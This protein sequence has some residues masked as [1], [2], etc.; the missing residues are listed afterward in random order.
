MG[1]KLTTAACVTVS[2][3]MLGGAL[4][5]VMART[6]SPDML[7]PVSAQELQTIKNKTKVQERTIAKSD[8]FFE[9]F[10]D[11]ATGGDGFSLPAGWTTVSTPGQDD[12]W[13]AGTLGDGSDAINGVSGW[14]YGFILGGTGTYDHD[15]W[16]FSPA[17]TLTK[18]TH[19]LDFYAYMPAVPGQTVASALEVYLC[20]KPQI[21][22]SVADLATNYENLRRWTPFTNEFNVDEDGEYYLGFRCLSPAAANATMIDNVRISNGQNPEFSG[23]TSLDFGTIDARAGKSFKNYSMTNLGNAP[24]EVNVKECSPE[25]EVTGVPLTIGTGD[26]SIYGSYGSGEIK[27]ALKYDKADEYEGYVVLETS[28]PKHSEVRI[29]VTAS[30]KDYSECDGI[31][32]SFEKGDPVDWDM[33]EEYWIL[34]AY[35]AQDG[36]TAWYSRTVYIPRN[37]ELGGIGFTTNYVRLGEDPV[38][39]FWYKA[40]ETNWRG[41]AVGPA[42]A[43]KLSARVLVSGEMGEWHEVYALDPEGEVKHNPISEFQKIEVRVPEFKNETHRVRIV[44]N[45]V[46]NYRYDLLI[47]NVRVGTIPDDDISLSSLVGPAAIIAGQEGTYTVG[48][49]NNGNTDITAARL[50]L[51]D[52][53]TGDK[54]ADMACP[55]IGA[56]EKTEF[57]FNWTPAE[58][59]YYHLAVEAFNDNDPNPANNISYPLHVS[60]LGDDCSVAIVD[61]TQGKKPLTGSAFPVNFNSL[62]CQTQTIYYANELGID[63][64]RINSIKYKTL[65]QNAYLSDNFAIYVAETNLGDF[66][67]GAFVPDDRFT[68][69]F[70]GNVYFREGSHELVIPFSTPYDYKGGNLVIMAKRIA[71]NFMYGVDFNLVEAFTERSIQA[72]SLNPGSVFGVENP[73]VR[74]NNVYPEIAINIVEAPHGSISGTIRDT[75]GTPVPDVKVSVKGTQLYALTDASGKYTLPKVAEGDVVLEFDGHDYYLTESIKV[76]LAKSQNLTVD[77]VVTH[78]PVARLSGTVTDES[79]ENGID[80]VRVDVKGHNNHTVFTSE[81]GSYGIEDICADTGKDYKVTWENP[82]FLPVTRTLPINSDMVE[83]IKLTPKPSR[84]GIIVTNTDEESECSLKWNAPLPEYSYDSGVPSDFVGWQNGFNQMIV[85]AAFLKKIDIREVSWYCGSTQLPHR[86]FNVIIFGLFPDGTPNPN[87]ILYVAENVEQTDDAWSTHRLTRKVSAD[88]FMVAISCDGFIAIG[89]SEPTENNPFEVGQNYYAG[90]SYLFHISE[91]STYMPAH[92]MI[93]AYGEDRGEWS[94]SGIKRDPVPTKFAGKPVPD[95]NIYRFAPGAPRDDWEKIATVS[96]NTFADP[97]FR[98]LDKGEVRY[99]VTAVYD[100]VESIELLSP[101]IDKTTDGVVTV[102]DDEVRIYLENDALLISDPTKV[103]EIAIHDLGGRGLGL[104]KTPG[105]RIDISH[106][107]SGV[108]LVSVKGTDGCVTTMKVVR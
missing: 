4:Y 45:N 93:R 29:A 55:A 85:G 99:A 25:I 9:D 15:C 1:N 73:E 76:A 96:E 59:R 32:E 60:V 62:E 69:V 24:L 38:I 89:V 98:N 30:G 58:A 41:D 83:D 65:L 27:V 31:V 92:F 71:P 91:M 47:D 100:G 82:Y 36:S 105:S 46:E 108:I 51:K 19:I 42:V 50:E 39:S 28:D 80:M 20:S 63:K 11:D 101:V 53:T 14:Q 18:G 75:E 78:Y 3:L 102:N 43:E 74:V 52:L 22:S 61:L 17:I 54:L 48:I 79:G 44:F 6:E 67:D 10:E 90:D 81:N 56:R 68:K 23:A 88:G 107:A 77:G 26:P 35:G 33:C 94:G 57:E 104:W 37:L 13:M 84:P 2:T 72:S 21:D 64:G 106:I 5:N 86:N 49:E 12:K 40:Y 7:K 8:Y 95:Y 87:N 103:E 34:N 66:S 97:D 16:L 70:E